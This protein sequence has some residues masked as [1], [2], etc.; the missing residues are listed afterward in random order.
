M[1]RYKKYVAQLS[2]DASA[3]TFHGRVVGTRDVLDFY[4]RTPEELRRAF[5]STVEDYVAWCAAEGVE[6][7]KTWSGKLT[8]RTSPE[9]RHR[10]VL[11][12]A[13]SGQSIN[14]WI[15]EVLER[16]ARK[17]LEASD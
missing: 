14:S 12:S 10:L 9:L 17:M 13:A 7:Q 4:G 16:E 6:P 8:L 2:Y 11:A 15:T 3:D 5:A 1:I